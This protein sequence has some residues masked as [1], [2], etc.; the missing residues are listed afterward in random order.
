[1]S[2]GAQD[3]F[4]YP[5]HEFMRDKPNIHLSLTRECRNVEKRRGD[6]T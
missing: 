1:M 5:Q 2:L 3:N 6:G 4:N